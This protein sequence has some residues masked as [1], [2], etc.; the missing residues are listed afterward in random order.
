MAAEK[1]APVPT[2]LYAIEVHDAETGEL[3]HVVSHPVRAPT[4][5]MAIW[6]T[7][8]VYAFRLRHWRLQAVA[9]ETHFP[10]TEAAA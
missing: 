8:R 7:L 9:A 4:P 10:Q 5:A 6:E 3:Y 2:Q 1:P